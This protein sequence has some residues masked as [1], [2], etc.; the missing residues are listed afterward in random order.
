[1]A[2]SSEPP[3]IP[4]DRIAG[5]VAILG[6]LVF[7]L[8]PLTSSRPPG[9]GDR[10]GQALGHEDVDARLW[11]D[12]FE[13]VKNSHALLKGHSRDSED[14]AHLLD[15]LQDQLKDQ[16]KDQ[17]TTAKFDPAKPLYIIPVLLPGGP[18]PENAEWRLRMRHAVLSG[19]SVAQYIPV[20]PEHI[21][22]IE[23]PWVR[24][25]TDRTL[26]S[27]IENDKH[28]SRLVT[29]IRDLVSDSPPP[30]LDRNI[31]RITI[32]YE[33]CIPVRSTGAPGKEPPEYPAQ[34]RLAGRIL[35]LWLSDS[36]FSDNLPLRIRDLLSRLTKP[37]DGKSYVIKLIGPANS[38]SLRAL[39]TANVK[40]PPTTST[41]SS[42]ASDPQAASDPQI[43][44]LSPWATA[45]DAFL[46]DNKADFKENL[47]QQGMTLTR[48]VHTDD[49]VLKALVHELAL[50]NRDLKQDPAK[51]Y[52]HIIVVS[53][54]DTIYARTLEQQFFKIYADSVRMPGCGKK[55]APTGTE[56]SQWFSYLRGLD[57]KLSATDDDQPGKKSSDNGTLGS[58]A[59]YSTQP[60]ESP[61]GPNQLDY[62]RRLAVQLED[63]NTELKIRDNGVGIIAIGVLGTD[64]Y[65]KLLVLQALRREFPGILFFTTDLD[66]RLAYPAEVKWSHNLVVASSFGYTLRPD[67]QQNIPPFRDTYQTAAFYTVLNALQPD[68]HQNDTIGSPRIF[69]ISHTGPYDLGPEPP[70]DDVHPPPPHVTALRSTDWYPRGVLVA[71]FLVLLSY[72]VPPL[73]RMLVLPLSSRKIK[74]LLLVYVS[75]GPRKW[76]PKQIE[77]AR[78]LSMLILS[79]VYLTC[80][81]YLFYRALHDN[82]GGSG[83]P[84]EWLLGISIWPT[85]FIRSFAIYLVIAFLIWGC[86]DLKLDRVGIE[87]DFNLKGDGRFPWIG[88][89]KYLSI[90]G[91]ALPERKEIDTDAK[92]PTTPGAAS[93]EAFAIP[94]ETP[95]ASPEPQPKVDSAD[96]DA[97]KLWLEFLIR[98]NCGLRFLR[99][100]IWTVVAF[101]FCRFVFIV[102]G[103]SSVPYRGVL[104]NQVDHYVMWSLAFL[105]LFLTFAVVDATKLC[106]RLID[107]LTSGDTL[108]RDAEQNDRFGG[109]HP[110]DIRQILDLELIARRT[111][112]VSRFVYYPFIILLLIIISRL[113]FF[114]N[115][116]WPIALV[117]VISFILLYALICSLQL[118]TAAEKAR[119]RT[120]ERLNTNLL[121][122]DDTRRR[123]AIKKMIKD[124]EDFSQGAFAPLYKQ[125]VVGSI[126]IPWAG[127]GAA[128]I[129]EFL[130]R[131]H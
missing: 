10:S 55:A 73:K 72:Q 95:E 7:L 75:P 16:L 27:G 59:G 71:L 5:I 119:K 12:P 22:Y 109:A 49:V 57:G 58:L 47:R 128:F 97:K 113:H 93:P 108:W 53:E 114:A 34:K 116:E 41:A 102:F 63:Y 89:W 76:T 60:L 131:S 74:L 37:L 82:E 104:S 121:R 81:A 129:L 67:L 106:T 98:Q 105:L 117:V 52:K 103:H 15:D 110:E 111:A 86:F 96:V 17:L 90:S 77:I 126:L 40:P 84:L 24:E 101:F 48:T 32:P 26:S 25:I 112:T 42:P 107:H 115:W 80:F 124:A 30:P 39:V 33:W 6:T 78:T 127:V 28:T 69:E 19:I 11:Q 35:V 66:A 46:S 99:A 130:T 83:E 51:Y 92:S 1:M 21:G 50:R 44:I 91:W 13:A 2:N 118:R 14:R 8:A 29:Y 87:E 125:P 9:N 68:R 4:W 88:F 36:D 65:D 20:D 120:I 18:Y 122:A 23:I 45:P 100:F 43:D 54:W 56:Q 79:L 64:V 123:R 3:S 61:N 70:K 31:T 94:V 62:L 38:D 85:E